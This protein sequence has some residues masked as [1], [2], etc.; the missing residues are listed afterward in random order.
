MRLFNP[1]RLRWPKLLGYATDFFRLNR[2][3]HNKSFTA[4]SQAS[5]VGGRNVGDE[6]FGAT[7]G[8]NLPTIWWMR[9]SSPG[10]NSR[11]PLSVRKGDSSPRAS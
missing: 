11:R 5:I 6:Y 3:M 2:R 8:I 1:F 4:D 10:P 9:A 7:A